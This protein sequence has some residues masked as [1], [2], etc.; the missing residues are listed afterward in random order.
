MQ[1][2]GG[3]ISKK[4]GKSKRMKRLRQT[5]MKWAIFTFSLAVCQHQN[6]N[7]ATLKNGILALS[8]E[9]ISIIIGPHMQLFITLTLH[10]EGGWKNRQAHTCYL[11]PGI[12]I[13]LSELSF[14]SGPSA[15]PLLQTVLSSCPWV[16]NTQPYQQNW[17]Q[18][19][20]LIRMTS[21]MPWTVE[22]CHPHDSRKPF[23]VLK[24]LRVQDSATRTFRHLNLHGTGK[25]IGAEMAGVG[26]SAKDGENH[27][28]FL[29]KFLLLSKRN[30]KSSRL[31]QKFKDKLAESK[32]SLSTFCDACWETA[33]IPI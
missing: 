4:Q 17:A 27:S 1:T 22:L 30:E 23:Q 19:E 11:C 21:G 29:S 28:A 26:T 2:Q 24:I 12:A 18:Q 33:V 10:G 32:R 7:G 15:R 6:K 9:V 8:E 25:L 14:K 3:L 16:P 5:F 13:L 20:P 31:G